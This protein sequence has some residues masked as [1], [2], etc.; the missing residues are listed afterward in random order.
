MTVEDIH[1]SDTG[2]QAFDVTPPIEPPTPPAPQTS[3]QPAQAPAQQAVSQQ[4]QDVNAYETIIAQ[5]QAQI[6]ALI[7]QTNAQS[8]QIT[9]M[10]QN[11][12]QFTQSQNDYE[13]RFQYAQN[14]AP[15]QATPQ[16]FP[17]YYDPAS[18]MQQFNP[19]SLAQQGDFSL[20]GL[21]NEIGKRD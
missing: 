4:T 8:A 9:Q 10:V 16:Q 19:P 13:S 15:I 14:F 7:A 3:Q 21:A 2:I 18:P 6:N 20:E 1:T 5:Q 11:G 17:N 12:A